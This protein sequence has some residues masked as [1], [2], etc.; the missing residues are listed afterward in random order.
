M[1]MCTPMGLLSTTHFFVE[2]RGR[3]VGEEHVVLGVYSTWYPWI[4]VGRL[5]QVRCR[6]ERSQ[7]FA[8]SSAHTHTVHAGLP[9]G[10]GPFPPLGK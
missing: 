6:H 8:S 9:D 2:I 4:I 5:G 3:G 1:A 10:L 7:A